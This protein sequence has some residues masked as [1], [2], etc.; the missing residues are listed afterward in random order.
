MKVARVASQNY[1]PSAKVTTI[2]EQ[3]DHPWVGISQGFVSADNMLIWDTKL[4]L[5]VLSGIWA[6]DAWGGDNDRVLRLISAA[7]HDSYCRRR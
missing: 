5:S 3:S 1:I 7:C 4:P 6:E 2:N